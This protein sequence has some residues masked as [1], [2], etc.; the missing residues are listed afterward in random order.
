MFSDPCPA[1]ILQPPRRDPEFLNTLI[2]GTGIL[3]PYAKNPIGYM[4]QRNV[5]IQ[6]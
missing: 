4:Q 1:G 3:A 2:G 6:H 5:N